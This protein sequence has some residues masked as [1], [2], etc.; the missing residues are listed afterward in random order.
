MARIDNKSAVLA[1]VRAAMQDR[2]NQAVAEIAEE[3]R[4]KVEARVTQIALETAWNIDR[5]YT[6]EAREEEVNSTVRVRSAAP[7]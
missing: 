2:V 7:R 1:A 4:E 6:S 3:A 5:F